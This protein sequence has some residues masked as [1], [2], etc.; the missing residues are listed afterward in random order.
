[1]QYTSRKLEYNEAT[2]QKILTPIAQR[3]R[4]PAVYL[5]GSYARGTANENSDIDLLIETRGSRIRSLLD[6][7]ALHQELTEI[8][9]KEV[10]LVT[11]RSLEQS[12]TVPSDAAFRDNVL[13]ERVCLYAA[14]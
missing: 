10:D 5:F 13:H 12:C 11:A 14:S 9:G 7:A 8:L 1:M 2:L 3:Y 4:L 6:L